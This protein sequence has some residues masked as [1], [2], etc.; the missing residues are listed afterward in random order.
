VLTATDASGNSTTATAV[1]TVLD[2]TPPV[3]SLP[4]LI[5]AAEGPDGAVVTLPGAPAIDVVDPN[6]MVTY[7]PPSGQFPLGATLVT[8]TATHASGNVSIASFT[9]T[10]VDGASNLPVPLISH[11]DGVHDEGFLVTV[12]GRAI[13]AA[14]LVPLSGLSFSWSA[15]TEGAASPIATLSGIDLTQF[16]FIPNDNG[17]YRVV[18][19]VSESGGQ[20]AMTETTV[21]V[22]NL[23]PQ[24]E[25][26][27]VSQ[28]VSGGTRIDLT[29]IVHDFSPADE[30]AGFT[31]DW[32]V[33]RNGEPFVSDSSQAS[34]FSFAP[35][36]SGL[37]VASLTVTDKD[38]G[39]TTV[40]QM[41]GQPPTAADASIET[42][43]DMPV[44]GQLLATDRDGDAIM[45]SLVDGASNGTV[46]MSPDGSFVYTP[47]PDYEGEDSFTFLANDGTSDSNTATV[48]I[49]VTSVNDAP[50][51]YDG[52]LTA[53]EDALAA[54][55]LVASDVDSAELTY[56][57]VDTANAHG[58]VK[59]TDAATGAFNYV[60][61]ADYNGPASF[62]FQVND[63]QH[64]SNTGTVFITVNPVNDA[65]IAT[66]GAEQ[67]TDEGET[68]L[69]DGSGSVDVD[70]GDV[71]EYVWDFGDGST[72]VG[73]TPTH[74]FADDGTYTVTLTVTDSFGDSSTD[75]LTVTVHN[76]APSPTIVSIS[77]TLQEGNVIALRG[78]ATDPGALDVVRLAWT[79]S[80]NN[81]SET[82][83]RGPGSR[84]SF[85]PDDDGS[86]RIL[87]SASDQDGDSTVVETTVLVENSAPE[88]TNLALDR[89]V[90]G[91]NGTV[92]LSGQF[93]DR[94]TL[95]THI[96][97][98]D[99]GDGSHSPAVVDVLTRTFTATHS[100][101]DGGSVATT[102][103]NY[104][105]SARVIDDNGGENTANTS[106]LV[107]NLA[108]HNVSIDEGVLTYVFALGTPMTFAGA[109]S[110]AGTL[111]THT[112]VWTFS[113]VEGL[114][115]VTEMRTGS[116][117][118]TN[119][120]GTVQNS[121]AFDDDAINQD[122][123]GVY[124]VTLSVADDEMGATTS[125]AR[126]F[127]VYDPS[128]GFVTGGGWIDSPPGAYYPDSPLAGRATFGFVSK[129]K[130]G[131]NVPTGQTEFQFKIANLNF[132]SSSYEWLVVAGARA[133][134]KGVG[135]ING[136][137]SYGFMLTAID[138]QVNG[139]GNA[140]KFRIKIWDKN[141]GDAIV[142]DNQLGA[143]DDSTPSTALGGG[144]IV[145]HKGGM[146]LTASGGGSEHGAGEF[147]T[148]S[149][150]DAAVEEALAQWAAAGFHAS[151]IKRLSKV[152][153]ALAHLP[154][155]ILGI[156]SSSTNKVWLDIDGAGLGWSTDPSAGAYDL[157][158][159]V[160]HEIGHLLGVDH[161]DMDATLQPGEI[162]LAS[163]DVSTDARRIVRIR[164]RNERPNAVDVIFAD[165]ACSRYGV[166]RLEV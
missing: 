93:T 78:S 38:G 103:N 26:S 102:S 9:V 166:G 73:R 137:G 150:L 64:D 128:A 29:A 158:S 163:D 95:D 56:R 44:S 101:L 161:E 81:S 108:P 89:P 74:V 25:L 87:L 138:G 52:S 57:L 16:S 41:I 112:A 68:V 82:Y 132:H 139:G 109:F 13:D 119:G 134:Y 65:P 75:S 15:Y 92:T 147:L 69:F 72:G 76:L 98:V 84:F 24:V 156:A 17:R 18:L 21:F 12:T 8:A 37:Y 133:Q 115:T 48:T 91:E 80:R 88:M 104:T 157:V 60:P 120:S 160:S 23:A 159:A 129:Y 62:T 7:D 140:D 124:T 71:L 151:R 149:M 165:L 127:V 116:V 58:F 70:T 86:Y 106:I 145:I 162:R 85:I 42:A 79:V 22:G 55:T 97:T 50:L 118:E 33:T 63:G 35:D 94:G 43:K 125:D 141:N 146:N 27:Y 123:A 49:S 144:Q 148:Q 39:T 114:N 130:K 6:P 66:A 59:I 121:F 5:I 30:E 67:M 136:Q 47:G 28:P 77:D 117:T 45:F 53:D 155:E 154:G 54:D 11:L 10:V 51:A 111:D 153:F 61:D 105:I 122:G 142:Y 143:S 83:A 110:D 131:A 135:T 96:V 126:T 152:E 164:D 34:Q 90:V 32:S 36:G 2:T 46:D 14:T 3:L 107:N 40:E 20:I 1:V 100:Y 19:T 113:H 4:D 31:F 99:W